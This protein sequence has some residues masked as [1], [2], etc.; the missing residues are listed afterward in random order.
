VTITELCRELVSVD[1]CLSSGSEDMAKKIAFLSERLGLNYELQEEYVD[2]NTEYNIIV[3]P[4]PLSKTTPIYLFLN[5]L[6][7]SEPGPLGLWKNHCGNPFGLIIEQQRLKGLGI[8]E[9]KADIAAKL[10]ALSHVQS[11]SSSGFLR[12]SNTPNP[13]FLGVFGH[14]SGMKGIQRWLKK[15]PLPILHALVGEP[16]DLKPIFSVNGYAKVD[17]LV[18]YEED[19]IL[20]KQETLLK[21]AFT[22][23]TRLFKGDPQSGVDFDTSMNLLKDVFQYFE[24]LPGNALLMDFD[25]GTQFN[26]QPH[27][28]LTEIDITTHLRY[29]MI[30]K[31]TFLYKEFSKLHQKMK[32]YSNSSF[33]PSHLTFNIGLLRTRETDLCLTGIVRIPPHLTKDDIIQWEQLAQN[34]CK[35]LGARLQVTDYK[36]AYSHQRSLAQSPDI[37]VT[38][39]KTLRKTLQSLDLSQEEASLYLSN[40]ACLLGRKNI[41]T[42]A[43]GPGHAR[44]NL[45]SPQEHVLIQ[46]VE[47]AYQFYCTWIEKIKE[48]S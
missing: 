12:S 44:C 35:N 22:T 40:E 18:P 45:H 9:N 13:V 26:S 2:G 20:L 1:S 32:S 16:T 3:S 17:I 48:M 23:S 36:P 11:N 5:H 37:W 31:V 14:Y 43:F 29:S 10:L 47:K 24:Q 19:E 15:N 30:K 42:L 8:A 34:I 28:I 33:T 25:G 27:Q 4:Y 38:L 7:C 39:K 46:D 21:D 6:D 41:P